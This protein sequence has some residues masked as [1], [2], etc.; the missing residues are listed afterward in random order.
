MIYYVVGRRLSVPSFGFLQE[1]ATLV[2]GSHIGIHRSSIWAKVLQHGGI[3]LQTVRISQKRPQRRFT[4]GTSQKLQRV[5]PDCPLRVVEAG[6]RLDVHQTAGTLAVA[7]AACPMEVVVAAQ[8]ACPL[9]VVEAG[10]PLDVRQT[11]G[12][13]AVAQAACP[14]EVV[15]A[16]QPAFPLGVVE[17]VCPLDI[18]QTI[19]PF[20]IVAAV[21]AADDS[22]QNCFQF[23]PADGD[24]GLSSAVVASDAGATEGTVDEG[25]TSLH[26]SAG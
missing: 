3:S 13:L 17:E 26:L 22:E 16:A 6:C 18:H 5:E 4:T 15:V 20:A 7:Q 10:C 14:M 21:A 1:A 12:P 2:K 23:V 25:A 24:G 19:G 9:R 8:P 11:A